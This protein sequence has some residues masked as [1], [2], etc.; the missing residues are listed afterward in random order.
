MGVRK[1][2]EESATAFAWERKLNQ[3]TLTWSDGAT[4]QL[5]ENTKSKSTIFLPLLFPIPA[6]TGKEEGEIPTD[7]I[8]AFCHACTRAIGILHQLSG[9]LA[10]KEKL[11][12]PNVQRNTHNDIKSGGRVMERLWAAG[13]AALVMKS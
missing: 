13:P 9:D 5:W 3:S 4:S 11:N 7:V 8:R 12:S 2:N 1:C 10:E 6:G